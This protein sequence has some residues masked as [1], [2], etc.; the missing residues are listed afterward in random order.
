MFQKVCRHQFHFRIAEYNS[1]QQM[2]QTNDLKE[3]SFFR[4]SHF[5]LLLLLQQDLLLQFQNR[6]YP[7]VFQTSLFHSV[8][9]FEQFFHD[10]CDR[11][12]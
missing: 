10:L 2:N 5:L 1:V 12:H 3:L 11:V 8:L 6:F 9:R 7:Q 4:E